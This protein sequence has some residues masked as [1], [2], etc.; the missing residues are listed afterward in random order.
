MK[1]LIVASNNRHSNFAPFIV[2]QADAIKRMGH[3][4][5]FFGI[6]GKGLLGYAKNRKL[7]IRKIKEFNPDIIHAHYGLSGLLANMQRSVPVVTH[8]VP[9]YAI[10]GGNPAKIIRK[11]K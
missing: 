6:N 11:R 5:D 4:V 8:D 1:V 9:D 10:V 7:L 2:E 3:E